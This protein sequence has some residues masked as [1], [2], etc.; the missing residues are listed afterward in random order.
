MIYLPLILVC[1]LAPGFLGDAD[2][3]ATCRLF[4][5]LR[6]PGYAT[7]TE[8]RARVEEMAEE[9]LA[10]KKKLHAILPGPWSVK[11]RCEMEVLNE[12]VV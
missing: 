6:Q 3:G 7:L 5:D 12:K 1:S 8:C 4:H 9:L 2:T 11:G 10:D